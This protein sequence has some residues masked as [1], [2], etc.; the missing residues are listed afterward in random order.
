[1]DQFGL[2]RTQKELF[3]KYKIRQYED[4]IKLVIDGELKVDLSDIERLRYIHKGL[5]YLQYNLIDQFENLIRKELKK[6]I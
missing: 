1:M 4:V 3:G 6:T 5:V 2:M